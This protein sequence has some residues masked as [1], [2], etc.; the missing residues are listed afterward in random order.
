MSHVFPWNAVLAF[1]LGTLRMS[2]SEFWRATP[3]ELLAM[4]GASRAAPPPRDALEALL[5]RFPDINGDRH[6]R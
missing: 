6:E 5:A 3:R 1:G 4:A 2:P